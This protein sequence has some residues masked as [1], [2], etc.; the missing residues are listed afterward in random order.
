M[1]ENILVLKNM[2]TVNMAQINF[3]WGLKVLEIIGNQ[4]ERFKKIFLT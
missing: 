1:V 2:F 3:Q 4:N